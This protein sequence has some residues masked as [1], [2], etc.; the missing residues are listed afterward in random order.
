MLW[1]DPEETLLEE[2]ERVASNLWQENWQDE[3]V[4]R[5]NWT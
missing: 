2:L 1:V 3:E 4:E 5:E